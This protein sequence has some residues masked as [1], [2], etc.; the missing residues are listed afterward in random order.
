MSN[1]IGD[2]FKVLT[3]GES[4]GSFL[5]CI[6]DN[7]P[8]GFLLIKNKVQKLLDLRKP[9]KSKFVSLRKEEDKFR[10]ISGIFNNRTTG[11]PLGLIIYN[12]N[13]RSVDY[14]NISE[15]F[16]PGHADYTYYKKYCLR[17]YKGGGRSSARTTVSLVLAGGICKYILKDIYCIDIFSY[18]TS[19]GGNIIDGNIDYFIKKVLKKKDSLGATVNVS[20]GNMP[21]GI[22]EPLFKKIESEITKIIIGL[23]AVKAIEFGSGIKCSL[24]FGSKS[25]DNLYKC[26]FK[27]N[28][29]GGI[30]GGI[31]TGQN[32]KFTVFIKPTS[33]ISKS[34]DT[35]N[36][37][38]FEEK[39]T[40][41]GRHDPCVGL[42]I[43]PIIDSAI[44][45]VIFNLLLKHK[46]SY[47]F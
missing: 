16:R 29:S 31:S 21:S 23:N 9:G 33:S 42:R 27:S 32:I 39:I 11:T 18:L 28:K 37:N 40:T 24:S 46:F 36:K 41:I 14:N 17:D 25:N 15:K 34:Q 8:S 22:G 20:I 1:I 43:M 47:F 38:L 26:G 7:I 13:K 10:I 6:I 3:F 2:Y 35:I 19:I 12:K 4:H 45:I 30:L 44:S 5:G